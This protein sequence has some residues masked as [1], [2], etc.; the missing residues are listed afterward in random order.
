MMVS[1]GILFFT[2]T[3]Y[4]YMF[5]GK[6]SDEVE[7][8]ANWPIVEFLILIISVEHAMLLLKIFIEHLIPE[9]PAFVKEGEQ[10]KNIIAQQ[11]YQKIKHKDQTANQ[12]RFMESSMKS[13]AQ[14]L[15][16]T[17]DNDTKENL[18]WC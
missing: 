4:K 2:S 13:L 16:K 15:K 3:V 17:I 14:N 9:T 1:A 10:E 7:P 6:K 12:G 11:L 5:T 18:E 8:I